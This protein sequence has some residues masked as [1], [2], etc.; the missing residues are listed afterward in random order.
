M[1][2]FERWLQSRLTAHGFPVP[3][4]GVWDRPDID[5]LKAFQKAR[6]LSVSGVSDSLS[7]AALRAEPDTPGATVPAPV[8][9]MPPWMAEMHRKMGLHEVRDN[10]VLS[11]W[12]KIGR[13]LGNPA[14]LPWCGDAV[15]SVIAKTLPAEPLPANP[16]FAQAW[17]KFG[18]DTVVP[19]VGSIGVIRW[20]ASSG[21]VGIVAGIEG[22]TVYLL[23]GNQSNAINVSGFPRSKF[24]AFRWPKTYPR[25][26]YPPLR[27]K[28]TGVLTEASTR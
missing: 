15:E 3:V 20:N 19:L 9:S 16:F 26:S 10:A 2:D 13:F 25:K 22:N 4:D 1:A 17:A 24:I 28:A 14:R 27:G 8:E 23:G 12:L 11:A 21:H 7:V 18:V 5:A 6:G